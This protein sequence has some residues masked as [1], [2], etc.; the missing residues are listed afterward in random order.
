[1]APHRVAPPAPAP[2]RVAEVRPLA[3]DAPAAA[4]VPPAA[5]Q[6]ARP[7]ALPET[8]FSEHVLRPHEIFGFAPYWNL[9]AAGGYPLRALTT[10]AYFGVDVQGDGSLLRGGAGWDGYQSGDLTA[11]LTRA[12]ASGAG[13]VLTAKQFDAATLHT[14]VTT[15]GAAARLSGE[16]AG[17]V[18][19]RGMDGVNLDLEGIGGAD[20]AAFADLAV[21]VANGLHAVDPR[22]QVTLDTYANS[23]GDTTGYFDIARLAPAMDA[24]FVMA[25]NM[26]GDNP[27]AVAPLRGAPSNDSESVAAYSAVAGSRKVILGMPFY[28]VDW[29]TASGDHAAAATG[30]PSPVTYAEL[31]AAG[32]PRYWDPATASPW[33]S[34]QEPTGQWHLA[35]YE[36]P[37]SIAMKAELADSARLRGVGIWALGMDGNDPAMA[38]AVLGHAAPVK[39]ALGP[40]PTAGAAPPPVA[41]APPPARPRPAPAPTPRP[42][43]KPP[44]PGPAPPPPLVPL[45]TPGP[46]PHSTLTRDGLSSAPR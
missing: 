5:P 2:G 20:R 27:S 1:M 18:R 43:P 46:V 44:V 36:D 29:P 38:R 16:L 41:M 14:L 32:H 31:T 22:W 26:Q 11:L 12:H 24:L 30:T 13:V 6:G 3:P 8:A 10:I 9:G 42:A 45:P 19:A 40:A 21:A 17:A 28:G 37:Q 33:T 23:A 4:V 34:W 25:Y 7:V 15:P 39:L 35:Y